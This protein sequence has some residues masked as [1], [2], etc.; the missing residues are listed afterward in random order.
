MNEKEKKKL[1]QK[2]LK[3]NGYTKKE[4]ARIMA[5]VFDDKDAKDKGS[6]NAD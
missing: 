6:N 3:R 1:A 2:V 4:I 5:R